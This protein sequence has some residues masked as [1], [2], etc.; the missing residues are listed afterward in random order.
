MENYPTME[1][2]DR[3]MDALYSDPRTS[4]AM[5]DVSNERGIVTLKGTVDSEEIRQAAEH[6]ARQ[7]EGVT[8]VINAIKVS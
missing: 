6:I 7:Q 1:T 2:V 3:V 4:E 8:I 5:I